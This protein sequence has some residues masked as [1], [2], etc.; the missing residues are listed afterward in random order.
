MCGWPAVYNTFNVQPHLVSRPTHRQFWTAA[1]NSWT[2]ATAAA[3]GDR[4]GNGSEG[5][6]MADVVLV[7]TARIGLDTRFL[8]YFNCLR[9]IRQ[10]TVNFPG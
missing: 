8:R 9:Y 4:P 2:D 3:T 1:Q 5:S 6:F 7:E 10:P